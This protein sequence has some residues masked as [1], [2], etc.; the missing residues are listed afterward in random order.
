[1]DM[2]QLISCIHITIA[3]LLF[4]QAKSST[5]APKE[6]TTGC[7][8]D[9]RIALLALRAGLS[10]PSNLLSS[11]NGGDCCRWKG[12][13]CSNSTGHV[14]ELDLHGPDCSYN[15]GSERVLG[16]IISS[17]LVDLHHLQYLNLSCNYFRG[18]KIP[19]FFGSLRNLEHLDLSLSYFSGMIPPQLGNLSNLRYFILDSID[20]SNYVYSTDITWLSRLSSLEHLDMSSVNLGSI[21]NWVPVLNMLPSL[22]FLRLF[23]CQLNSSPDSI[24]HLFSNKEHSPSLC[25]NRCTRLALLNKISQVTTNSSSLITTTE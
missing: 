12:V 22:K 13:R 8:A 16:G 24:L 18:A 5:E 3:L 10:D 20:S 7:I 21:Q 2:L 17:S 25:I 6:T 4:T 1:M 9:E 15:L 23:R 11:W 19:E 14:V